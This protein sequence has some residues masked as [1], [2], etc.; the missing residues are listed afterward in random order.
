MKQGLINCAVTGLSQ[1]K[2]GEVLGIESSEYEP[3]LTPVLTY[4]IILPDNCDP[5]TFTP[6]LREIEEEIP[7]LQI[8]WD[9]KLKEIQVQI[10]GAVQ[11]EILQSLIKSRFD[12]D[13]EFDQGR[14]AY[15]ETITNTVEGV[16]HFEPLRHYAEVHLLLEPKKRGSGLEFAVDCSDDILAKIGR[17]S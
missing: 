5:R 16:G 9:E 6:K 8:V 10:M 13:V 11:I 17:T 7:E 2:A 14:I 12:I 3:I 15:K 4:Q 1:T